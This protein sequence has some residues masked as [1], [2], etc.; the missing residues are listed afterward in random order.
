MSVIGRG[1]ERTFFRH[2]ADKRELAKVA[3]L[4][5][6]AAAALRTRGLADR[7]ATLL[8]Q[9]GSAAIGQ[10]I[11]IWLDDPEADMDTVIVETFAD[12]HELAGV[13]SI[14]P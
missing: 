10:A 12:L 2:F 8:A 14:Q 7:R 6:T 3:L 1:T 13:E 4:S 11:H 5:E 9:V